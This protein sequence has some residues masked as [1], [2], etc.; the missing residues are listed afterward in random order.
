[1]MKRIIIGVVTALLLAGTSAA[2]RAEEGGAAHAEEGSAAHAEKG[3][4]AHAE[5][6]TEVEVGVKAW[7]NKLKRELPTG[8][9]FRSNSTTLL[10]P[11]VEVKFPNHVFAEASYMASLNDYRYTDEFGAEIKT[12][13]KDLDL[14]IG[15]AITPMVSVLAGYKESSFKEDGTGNK[16]TSY[17]PLAG[18]RGSYALNEK[19]SFYGVLNYL[20]TH[21]KAV[22]AAGT[23]REKSPGWIAELGLKYEVSSHAA[24]DLGYKYE[25][26]KGKDSKIE[27]TFDGLTLGVMYAF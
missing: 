16:E 10:G 4:A 19:T 9:T 13:R 2:V 27:D 1:M 11:A 26:T 5:E 6:G 15:Y 24:V 3:G 14:A 17:G 7:Y 12:D 21:L 23:V 8:E 20:L 25:T 18:V 22:D